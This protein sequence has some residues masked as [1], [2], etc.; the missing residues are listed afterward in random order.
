MG[1]HHVKDWWRDLGGREL[2]FEKGEY[3]FTV[4]YYGEQSDSKSI[5]SLSCDWEK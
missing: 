3:Q 5:Y 2:L 4:F 1:E